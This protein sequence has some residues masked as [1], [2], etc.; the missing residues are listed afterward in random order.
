MSELIFGC[1]YLGRRLAS[2]RLKDNRQLFGV[3]ST[4]AS[5]DDLCGL[6]IAPLQADLDQATLPNL[7]LQDSTIFYF[8]PPPKSGDIDSRVRRLIEEFEHQGQPRR[9]VY[10]STTGVYG[11]CNGEWVTEERPV[12]PVAPRAKRRWDAERS[13]RA[14]HTR[15]GRELVILRVAG[16]YGPG[17]LPLERLRKGLPLVRAEESP[18]TNRV[19]IDDLVQICVAAMDKGTDGEVYNVSDG[20]PGTMIDYFSQIALLAGLPP[21]PAIPLAQAEHDLSAGMLSYMRE[22]R[23]LD[24]SKI[25]QELGVTLL[26]PSIN[27]GL[28]ACFGK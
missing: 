14:W 2:V 8:I 23:R 22:S 24:N 9:I 4:V 3:V 16:I 11:D 17:K 25:K 10:L 7:P 19:H 27:S 15:T 21:P 20:S 18:W 12:K 5:M 1:G 26:Y 13:F 28:P 6:G